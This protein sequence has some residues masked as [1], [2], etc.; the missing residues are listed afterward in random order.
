MMG[1]HE[2]EMHEADIDRIVDVRVRRQVWEFEWMARTHGFVVGF[3]CGL[4]VMRW[5]V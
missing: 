1:P 2:R 3:V 5:M 4:A